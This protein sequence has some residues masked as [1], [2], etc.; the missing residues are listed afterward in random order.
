MIDSE[1]RTESFG[2]F[3]D[4]LATPIG[5][6]GRRDSVVSDTALADNPRGLLS[7]EILE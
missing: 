4:E 5:D 3:I 1:T 6:P 2:E 7:R